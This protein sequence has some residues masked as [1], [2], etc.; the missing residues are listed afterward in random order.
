MSNT[1]VL[2]KIATAEKLEHKLH[3]AWQY[4]Q[5]I[6]VQY[7]PSNS[8]NRMPE[9]AAEMIW[10]HGRYG[11]RSEALKKID[12]IH[13]VSAYLAKQKQGGEA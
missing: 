12:S 13:I 7:N 3:F 9:A 2:S 8:Y 4:C 6:N 1:S 10:A 11:K 5:E